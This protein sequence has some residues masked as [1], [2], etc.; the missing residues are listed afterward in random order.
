MS[1]REWY[2]EGRVPLHT[3]RADI[4]YGF[5]EAHTTYGSIGVKC[6]IFHGEVLPG[7]KSPTAPRRG[8]NS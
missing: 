2:R 4:D 6:W 8:G 7:P 1:R 5:T 3:L